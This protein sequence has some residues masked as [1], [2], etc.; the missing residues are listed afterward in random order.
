[1]KRL[2]A[3]AFAVAAASGCE[4]RART[5]PDFGRTPEPTQAET[6]PTPEPPPEGAWSLAVESTEDTCGLTMP[7]EVIYLSGD[8]R[9]WQ[10][11]LQSF[12]LDA[13]GVLEGDELAMTGSATVVHRP[14]IDCVLEDRDAWTLTRTA[15][16]TL[17]GELAR[18]REVVAGDA[19]AQVLA[20]GVELPCLTRWQV[21]LD[22]RSAKRAP[23]KTP[24]AQ[25]ETET[26]PP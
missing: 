6:L 19:C 15:P 8:G 13:S 23:P 7:P 3:I 21:R 18:V 22:H 1:M 10:V 17:Q 24:P 26:A 16:E 20:D 25:T 9:E 5:A 2:L 14:T 11:T 12:F 4:E